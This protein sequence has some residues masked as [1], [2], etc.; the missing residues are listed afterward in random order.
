ML[1]IARIHHGD[2]NGVAAHC[3]APCIRHIGAAQIGVGR[4]LEIP[5]MGGIT[6][7]IGRYR[8]GA[9]DTIRLRQFHAVVAHQTRRDHTRLRQ[10][11]GMIQADHMCA[12]RHRAHNRH[13][14]IGCF[15]QHAGIAYP[16]LAV[17]LIA[18][19][20]TWLHDEARHHFF[21][22]GAARNSQCGEPRRLR[23]ETCLTR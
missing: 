8:E 15:C 19:P 14:R 3:N 7:I 10:R 22:H 2:G 16:K 13:R 9:H 5:L 20:V 21:P 17:Q 6:R 12:A 11:D 4:G 18:S 1:A 23:V